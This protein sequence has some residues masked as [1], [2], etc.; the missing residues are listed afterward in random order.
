MF[1]KLVRN[2]KKRFK[3]N[4]S[5]FLFSSTSSDWSW[6]PWPPRSKWQSFTERI[7]ESD[8]RSSF[9]LQNRLGNSGLL[10]GTL[11]MW[12]R[13]WKIIRVLSW[14][15]K[16][17][18]VWLGA[19]SSNLKNKRK[20]MT[21]SLAH[22]LEKVRSPARAS[23]PPTWAACARS[24]SRSR[25]LPTRAPPSSCQCGRQRSRATPCEDTVAQIQCTPCNPKIPKCLSLPA[26]KAYRISWYFVN[27]SLPEFS[28]ME[29]FQRFPFE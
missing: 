17:S 5:N 8:R 29:L 10:F 13:G 26:N 18:G 7:G 1:G 14:S 28:P 12:E 20:K 24:V 3:G 15:P 6:P 23:T 4:E 22:F 27:F 2:K 9:R 21:H 19:K 25:R 11:A 16:C